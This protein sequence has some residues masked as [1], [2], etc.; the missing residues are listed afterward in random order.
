[1]PAVVSNSFIFLSNG[2]LQIYD[3][4]DELNYSAND[5]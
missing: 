2:G 4:E 3:V 5:K 1:M